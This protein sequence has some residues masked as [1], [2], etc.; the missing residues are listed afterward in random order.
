MYRGP[1]AEERAGMGQPVL[2]AIAPPHH[3]QALWDHTFLQRLWDEHASV[4]PVACSASF[5]INADA[6]KDTCLATDGTLV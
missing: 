3:E 1:D 5:S 4:G 6:G 2:C